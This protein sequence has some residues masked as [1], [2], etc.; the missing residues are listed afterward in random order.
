[1]VIVTARSMAI[2]L[3]L[4]LFM[5]AVIVLSSGSVAF[6]EENGGPGNGTSTNGT[7][8]CEVGLVYD[9]KP[10]CVCPEGSS[11]SYE[12]DYEGGEEIIISGVCEGSSTSL[13]GDDGSSLTTD[14]VTQSASVGETAYATSLPSTGLPQASLLASGLLA[15]GAAA[16]LMRRR[17]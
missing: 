7:P 10:D 17:R 12:Y 13:T 11:W 14:T 16:L 3:G 9:E 15:T 1:M 4:L 2:M 8:D 5:V 6:A